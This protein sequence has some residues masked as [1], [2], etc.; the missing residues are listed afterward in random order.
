MP[1]ESVRWTQL[2]GEG[3]VPLESRHTILA[4]LP[5]TDHVR[6]FDLS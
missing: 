1:S 4:Q 3:R 2:F 6:G 5:H